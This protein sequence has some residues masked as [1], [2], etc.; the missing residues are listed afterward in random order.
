L[1]LFAARACCPLSFSPISA[2]VWLKWHR[3]LLCAGLISRWTIHRYS[4][5]KFSRR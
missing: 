3:V 1:L 5:S 2:V 4:R